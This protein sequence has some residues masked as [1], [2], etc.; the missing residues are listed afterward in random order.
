MKL[1]TAE[2]AVKNINSGD[3]VF[4]Q[5]VAAAPQ[6]LI[7]AMT[8]RHEKLQ[9]VEI[10]HLHTEGVAPYAESQYKDS[11]HGN[12][13]FIGANVR[14]AVASGEADFI[15]CFLSEVPILMRGGVIPID[16]ALIQVSPPDKHGA[17]L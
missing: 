10:Y 7:K 6:T 13:F 9:N 3:R 14:A 8:A 11:F 17:T 12:S 4:I 5:S 2:E 1:I 16:V 15:P